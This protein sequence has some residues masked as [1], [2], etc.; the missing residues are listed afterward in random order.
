MGIEGRYRPAQQRASLAF[1]WNTSFVEGI[2]TI[3]VIK[4][5]ACD[6]RDEDCFSLKVRAT[7]PGHL[8]L[9]KKKPV[10]KTGFFAG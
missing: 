1:P 4:C 9:A 5:P 8:R 3:T 10:W 2:D 7:Q 6:H